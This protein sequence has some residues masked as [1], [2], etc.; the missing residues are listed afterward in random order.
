MKAVHPRGPPWEVSHTRHITKVIP[1]PSNEQRPPSETRPG[2]PPRC[3]R[4]IYK[5]IQGYLKP[6]HG[7]MVKTC[8]TSM[9]GSPQQSSAGSNPTGCAPPPD[10]EQK[11]SSPGSPLQKPRDS[12]PCRTFLPSHAAHSVPIHFIPVLPISPLHQKKKSL[13]IPILSGSKAGAA[14]VF[15]KAPCSVIRFFCG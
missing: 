6:H 2:V 14:R 11:P 10:E 9:K 5:E 15:Q 7:T 4:D 8:P 12:S 13:I 3:C 1:L